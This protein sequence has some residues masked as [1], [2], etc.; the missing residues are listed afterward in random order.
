MAYACMVHASWMRHFILPISNVIACELI[1]K[2]HADLFR[3]AFR[4]KVANADQADQLR[5]SQN[6]KSVV[7]HGQGGLSCIS[8]IPIVTS[9]VVTKLRHLHAVHFHLLKTTITDQ[10]TCP[11][12]TDRE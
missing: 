1:K 8:L 10:F 12:E 11:F 6:F 2:L 7:S 3:N 9:E 5:K 4:C